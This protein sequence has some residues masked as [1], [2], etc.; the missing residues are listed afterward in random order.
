MSIICIA[1][2]AFVSLPSVEFTTWIDTLLKCINNYK[3]LGNL[4]SVFISKM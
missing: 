3:C 2:F 4:K 1:H